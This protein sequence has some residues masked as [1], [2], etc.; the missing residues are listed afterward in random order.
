MRNGKSKYNDF[1][2]ASSL[3][4]YLYQVKYGLLDALRRT[5]RKND[6]ICQFELLDDVHFESGTE[7]E[8][9]QTKHHI[10]KA[11]KL[12]DASPDLWKALRIWS[13]HIKSEKYVE[14][15]IFY[16]I[17]T[18]V[19]SPGSAPC[20][21]KPSEKKGSAGTALERFTA[22][23]NSSTNV[24]NQP[25]YLAF[26]SL[27]GT[28]RRLLTDSI[29]I[30][31]GEPNVEDIDEELKKETFWASERRHLG[32]FI[33]RL[34]GWWIRRVVRLLMEEN[35]NPILSQEIYDEMASLRE[36]FKSD[37]L[38]IDADIL[39]MTVDAS[40]HNDKNFVRQLELINVSSRRI[41]LAIKNYLRAAA[42][43]SRWIREDLIM[44]GELDRYETSLRD[45]WE[46]RFEQM[47]DELGQSAAEDAMHEAA[48]ML[49]KFFETG[50]LPAIRPSCTE[51]FIARGTYQILADQLKVGWHPEFMNRLSSL[52]SPKEPEQ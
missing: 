36:Q 24:T 51:P 14:G 26:K 49:Y 18:A 7:I 46:L 15:T 20:Y 28:Q 2:A 10:S 3:I 16:L 22:T 8:L 9:L 34:E 25:A 43:R 31:D 27:D 29:V 33:K 19:A 12:T 23:A 30:L 37:N 21:L 11:A 5:R 17:T 38:P 39:E 4:G 42:Q 40:G 52:L 48:K 44:V 47:R 1:S 45:E 50:E 13:E 35:H 41:V 6:F 32:S